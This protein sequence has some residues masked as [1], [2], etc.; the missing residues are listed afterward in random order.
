VAHVNAGDLLATP[1]NIKWG[2][3]Q[4][5]SA[6]DRRMPR[7]HVQPSHAVECLCT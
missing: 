6:V 1:K 7:V 2:S 4:Q 5:G 3:V